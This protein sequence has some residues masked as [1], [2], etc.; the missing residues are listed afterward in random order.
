MSGGDVDLEQQQ[1]A[2]GVASGW[3]LPGP[4]RW[5]RSLAATTMPDLGLELGIDGGRGEG[6]HGGGWGEREWRRR[7]GARQERESSS[8]RLSG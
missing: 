1:V 7:S 5:R 4:G 8:R 3:P 6:E 2:D